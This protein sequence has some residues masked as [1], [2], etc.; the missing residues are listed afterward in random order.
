MHISTISMSLLGGVLIGLAAILLLLWSGRIAGIS[1]IL[2]GLIKPVAG[3]VAWR[4][5][6]VAGLLAGGAA[7]LVVDPGA[8]EVRAPASL[9]VIALAGLCVGYGSRLGSGCTSGHGV[10]GVSRLSARSLVATATFMLTGALTVYLF[11]SGA[12]G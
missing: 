8:L 1:G 4:A 7:L 11:H 5:A 10:C 2:A 6:F 12:I 3:E 9:G